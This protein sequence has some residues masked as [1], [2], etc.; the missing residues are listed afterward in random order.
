MLA[1]IY[2]PKQFTLKMP[3]NLSSD[4]NNDINCLNSEILVPLRGIDS[5]KTSVNKLSVYIMQ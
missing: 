1:D 2:C 4:Y 3:I 5:V